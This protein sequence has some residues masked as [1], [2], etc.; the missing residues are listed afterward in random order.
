MDVSLMKILILPVLYRM[1]T[2]FEAMKNQTLRS[3]YS[4]VLAHIIR[5]GQEAGEIR[6]DIPAEELSEYLGWLSVLVMIFR[7]SDPERSSVDKL[8]DREV[9][10]FLN[11]AREKN[12]S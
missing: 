2:G 12:Q 1:Q 7:L 9:D 8:V 5:M 3:G 10:L 4:G 11:G 6:R